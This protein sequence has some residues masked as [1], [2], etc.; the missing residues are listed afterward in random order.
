MKKRSSVFTTVALV[1]VIV[2]LGFGIYSA[3]VP[4]RV[5]NS[6]ILFDIADQEV[7]VSVNAAASWLEDS[8]SDKYFTTATTTTGMTKKNWSVP[9][10]VFSVEGEV[11]NHVTESDIVL[12]FQ[13]K[14]TEAEVKI[15]IDGIAYD[16]FEATKRFEAEVYFIKNDAGKSVERSYV[17]SENQETVELILPKYLENS[18]EPFV[19]ELKIKYRLL[20]AAYD[21]QSFAQNITISMETVEE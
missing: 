14:N 6:N 15:T 16:T 18:T 2:V 17:I 1:L 11:E 10:I 21:I 8:H 9:N 4:T 20:T 5:I 7:N 3:V 12:T 19:N 13:N